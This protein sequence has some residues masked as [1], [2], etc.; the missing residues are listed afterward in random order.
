MFLQTSSAD[1]S[2]LSPRHLFYKSD[3]TG[4]TWNMI[5]TGITSPNGTKFYM[6]DNLNYFIL[7]SSGVIY[8]STDGGGNWQMI[9]G[10]SNINNLYIYN[11]SNIYAAGSSNQL[12]KSTDGGNNWQTLI[13]PLSNYNY[14]S[15]NF[16][17]YNTGWV[18]GSKGSLLKTVDAGLTWTSGAKSFTTK[19]INDVRILNNNIILL[20]A[21]DGIITEHQTRVTTGQR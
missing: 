10:Y 3:N 15:L 8:K 2:S 6:A 11:I 5:N 4:L 18:S 16:I 21:A 13:N 12:I 9:P 14:F 19:K 17:N 20:A 1:M 7:S